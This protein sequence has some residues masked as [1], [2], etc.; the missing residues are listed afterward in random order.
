MTVVPPTINEN[1]LSFP[2]PCPPQR[3]PVGQIFDRGEEV[4]GCLRF[5][6]G[7]AQAPRQSLTI[8]PFSP[9]VFLALPR[10]ATTQQP[11]LK[12]SERTIQR[13]VLQEGKE[14]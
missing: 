4:G 10:S 1:Q 8:P 2:L 9:M 5:N 13:E 3:W 14:V 12:P 7:E 11:N 6:Y